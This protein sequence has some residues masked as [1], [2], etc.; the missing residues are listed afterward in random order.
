V[1]DFKQGQHF[2]H[3]AATCKD[4]IQHFSLKHQEE[5]WQNYL[6]YGVLIHQLAFI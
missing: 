3:I 1:A 5:L 6:K 2:A 4:K